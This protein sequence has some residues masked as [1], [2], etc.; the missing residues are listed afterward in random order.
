MNLLQALYSTV[1]IGTVDGYQYE[2]ESG[3][4]IKKDHALSVLY[5]LE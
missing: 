3:E 4:V 5:G 1:H 2:V